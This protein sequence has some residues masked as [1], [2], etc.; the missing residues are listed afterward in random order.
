MAM[1][2][3]SP[4]S[5][6][7]APA[8]RRSSA[9]AADSAETATVEPIERSISPAERTKTRP[10]AMMV[11]GAVCSTMLERLRTVRKPL[12]RSMIAKN[13]KIARKPR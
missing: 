8:P 12:S 2:A 9:T 11:I 4:A 10:I 13:R 1:P 6:A 7:A 3:P 5:T